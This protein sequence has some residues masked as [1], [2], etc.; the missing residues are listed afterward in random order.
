MVRKVEKFSISM[1]EETLARLERFA[2]ENGLNRSASISVLVNQ[3]LGERKIRTL[4]GTKP[5][6]IEKLRGL[7]IVFTDNTNSE[8]F[9]SSLLK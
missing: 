9:A 3:A 2:K 1:C 4:V 5:E 6:V 7:N 8:E